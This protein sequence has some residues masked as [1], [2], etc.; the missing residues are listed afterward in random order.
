MK[1]APHTPLAVSAFTRRGF[2]LLEMM[3]VMFIIS[4]L[5]AAVF[6]I[7]NSVTQLT[8]DMTVTQQREA[9]RTGFHQLCARTF[10]KLPPSAIVRLRNAQTGGQLSST[11][12]LV[13]AVSPLTGD[14]GGVTVLE[15][16]KGLDGYMRVLLRT[17]RYDE[18]AAW[19][20]GDTQ[21]GLRVPLLEGVASLEWKFLHSLSGEWSPFWNEKL[22]LSMLTTSSGAPSPILPQAP[23]PGMVEMH[24]AFGIEPPQRH[25]FWVPPAQPPNT[26]GN[27]GGMTPPPSPSPDQPPPPVE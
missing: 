21:V 18:V 17:L 20:R 16:E 25:I 6:G 27:P 11:I 14:A 9:R 3:L 24:I 5:V 23:R 2:T 4:L 7:V 10:R 15:T 1:P 8:N 26:R 19:E 12:T 22:D 13:G